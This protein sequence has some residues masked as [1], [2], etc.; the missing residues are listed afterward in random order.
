MIEADWHGCNHI[1][2]FSP[3]FDSFL[4]IRKGD[5]AI[6]RHTR[7]I[8]K[9][10]FLSVL[11]P[12]VSSYELSNLDIICSKKHLLYMG[13]FLKEEYL[14]M[15]R[16]L[17]QTIIQ[18]TNLEGIDI[19]IITSHERKEA[20]QTIANDLNISLRT[21]I[22][23]N[24]IAARDA[25]IAKL[26]IFDYEHIDDY[27]KILYLDTDMLTQKDLSPIFK[28]PIENRTYFV[29]EGTIEDDF[30]GS[31]FF[32]LTQMD[33]TIVGM[34]GGGFFFPNTPEIKTLFQICR[35]HIV[36]HKNQSFPKPECFEQPY[37]NYH[38]IRSGYY[39]STVL[40]EYIQLSLHN[41]TIKPNTSIIHFA[42][43]Q[44]NVQNKIIRMKDYIES[45]LQEPTTREPGKYL[46]YAC[47]FYNKD[48]TELLRLLIASTKFYSSLKGITFLVLTSKEIEPAIQD[49]AKSY[50]FPILTKTFDYTTIFQAACARLSIFDY[51]EIGSYEKILYL[52]TDI[53]IKGSL[54]TLFDL[55]LENKLYGLE[56]GFTDS[57]NFG[58]QFFHPP[59]KT[60]GINS[61]TLLFPN[62]PI[63]QSLFQR[64][65]GHVET[66]TKSGSAPP[67]SLDQPF[68]NYHAIKDGLYD[69]QILKPYVALFEGEGAPENENTAIVCHFSF[70]IGNFGHKCNR[71]KAYLNKCLNH[72]TIEDKFG[73]QN[74][75]VKKRFS[76]GPGF[77][78]FE[79]KNVL[80]T[81]W[82]KG[83]YEYI[84]QNTICVEWHRHFH[85]IQIKENRLFGLRTWP[86]DF[87]ACIGQ[88]ITP[89]PIT[90][91][92]PVKIL[93]IILSCLKHKHLWPSIS[94]RLNENT[95]ILCGGAEETKLE[96]N[97]L[98]LN[99]IDTYD[100]LSEK[101]MKAYEFILQS[102]RFTG[103]THILKG[104]DHDTYFTLQQVKDIETG[105]RDILNKQDYVGQQLFNTDQ[106]SGRVHHFGK[107]PKT[108]PWYNV[109]LTEPFVPFLGGGEVYILS[110]KSLNAIVSNK[111][112]Y[113]KFCGYEDRMIGTILNKH[114]ITPYQLDLKIKTWIG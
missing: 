37:L 7:H 20:V 61:G 69:N 47:V 50:E 24:V 49:L 41:P 111:Q 53:L 60:S 35:D 107:V 96:G 55:P 6:A 21:M 88:D 17:L 113:A 65:R 26:N 67:Y 75:L 9:D 43:N 2:Q 29:G 56:S 104:D 64:I 110:K 82:G 93:T 95:I 36:L 100:G 48:Y 71:M 105:H 80:I 34:N 28:L 72:F 102:E 98:Y 52:D 10:P 33:R 114:S 46:V 97:I 38:F 63:I 3:T 112:E 39:N 19:L 58:V 4:S 1:L 18:Y 83:T 5:C 94:E 59:I 16:L 57:I 15:L 14:A 54:T 51:E 62:S 79:D 66:Y 70:P 68:I 85:I 78:E 27:G 89:S 103:F 106:T 32:D 90:N 73:I 81:T 77:I 45:F 108:S 101:M 44:E 11:Y 22:V 92:N 74:D 25:S 12:K 8:Q 99:C 87:V 23:E 76:F 40:S 31:W 30:H 42:G 91:S 109:P 84:T 86:N 13:V